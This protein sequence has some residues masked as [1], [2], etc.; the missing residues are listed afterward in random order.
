VTSNNRTEAKANKDIPREDIAR[1]LTTP[2]LM[3]Y[4]GE[5]E[6]FSDPERKRVIFYGF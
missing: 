5:S 2:A 4:L 6:I 3:E 1:I